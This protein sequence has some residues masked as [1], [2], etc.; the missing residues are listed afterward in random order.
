M[1]ADRHDTLQHG[2]LRYEKTSNK[3]TKPKCM[4]VGYNSDHQHGIYVSMGLARPPA[5]HLCI[6]GICNF[7]VCVLTV[8]SINAMSLTAKHYVNTTQTTNEACM[9]K[10]STVYRLTAQTKSKVAVAL[11]INAGGSY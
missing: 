4:S 8:K 11:V 2:V 3:S 7:T 9:S 1:Q 10:L 5:W 6:Y